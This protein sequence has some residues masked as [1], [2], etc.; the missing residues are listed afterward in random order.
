[1]QI[2]VL[3][4][5]FFV[6]LRKEKNMKGKVTQLMPQKGIQRHLKIHFWVG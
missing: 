6:A 2:Y 3:A 5:D 1:M 4:P